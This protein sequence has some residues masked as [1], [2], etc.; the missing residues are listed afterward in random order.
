MPT[1][2]DNARAAC[3]WQGSS[4]CS[5]R[6]KQFL[7]D[8][9]TISLKDIKTGIQRVVR[10]ILGHWLQDPPEDYR[11]ELIRLDQGKY[12]YAKTYMRELFGTVTDDAPD[13]PVLVATGDIFVGL[14]LCTALIHHE[15]LFLP[16]VLVEFKYFL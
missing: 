12:V 2:Q 3:A 9:S 11:I 4:C 10:S 8:V 16:G 7:V 15:S 6:Q 14:D 13:S 5:N 1:Q